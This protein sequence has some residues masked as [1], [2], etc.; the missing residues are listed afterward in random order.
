MP[1]LIDGHN[2]IA[3]RPGQRL[4]DPDDELELLADLG[5]FAARRR[6]SVE[7]YFDRGA[8]GAP[9]PRT[10]HGVRAL[11]I[12]PPRTADDALRDR[13]A[14]LGA[15]ARGWTVVSSDEQVRRWARRAGARTLT[16]R[17]FAR[18]LDPPQAAGEDKAERPL[19]ED[20]LA[21]WQRLFTRRRRGGAG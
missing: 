14:T 8:P 20:E 16:S 7:V 21:F 10:A 18:L 9:P 1:F 11:F 2:L 5:A 6:T 4:S 19:A 3:Q 12:R 17:E 15:R 13:L